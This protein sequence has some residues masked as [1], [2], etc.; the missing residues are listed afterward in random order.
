MPCVSGIILSLTLV[1]VW[2][3]RRKALLFEYLTMTSPESWTVV[4]T[5]S[6]PINYSHKD[7]GRPEVKQHFMKLLSPVCKQSVSLSIVQAWLTPLLYLCSRWGL[8]FTKKS[9]PLPFC[10][11]IRHDLPEQSW[12]G[13]D[14][15]W[16]GLYRQLIAPH[17]HTVCVVH[18]EVIIT[19]EYLTRLLWIVLRYAHCL[20]IQPRPLSPGQAHCR[21]SNHDPLVV[22]LVMQITN[23]LYT[24]CASVMH[25]TELP[26]H[27]H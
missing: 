27:A 23:D 11:S 2:G 21:L 18:L 24:N 5:P 26:S 15:T 10:H 7:G 13:L 1:S 17:I 16:L 9:I 12:K 8:T 25:T 19:A 22:F 6:V 14:P 4:T 20:L 3:L